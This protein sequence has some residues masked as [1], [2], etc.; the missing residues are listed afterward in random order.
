[1]HGYISVV[2]VSWPEQQTR[3][4]RENIGAAEKK[5]VHH[6]V[7]SCLFGITN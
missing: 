2:R 6:E 1:M 3:T 4:Q 7:V 5:I